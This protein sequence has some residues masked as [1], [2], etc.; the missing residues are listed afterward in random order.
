MKIEDLLKR[1]KWEQIP[2]T[3]GRFTLSPSEKSLS[4]EALIDSEEVQIKQ[5]PSAHPDEL[6]HVVELE[7]GG[8]I[9]YQRKDATCIHTLNSKNMFKR[10]QWE[11]GIISYSPRQMPEEHHQTP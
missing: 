5:Y 9:S 2:N 10:K 3:K 7:D 6:I 11:L 1:F 8:L 4:V